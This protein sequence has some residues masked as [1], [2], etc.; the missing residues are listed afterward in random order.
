MGAENRKRDKVQSS[1]LRS[2]RSRGRG[3][4]GSGDRWGLSRV[5][6]RV[7]Q[8][9]HSV[10]QIPETRSALSNGNERGMAESGRGKDRGV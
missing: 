9:H 3:D 1:P 5:P 4:K 10:L 7:W 8:A 2:V 6:W